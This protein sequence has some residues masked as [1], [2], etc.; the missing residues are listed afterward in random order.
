MQRRPG[1]TL[2]EMLVATGLTIFIMVILSQ[3]FVAGLETFRQL[4]ALGDMESNLR[5][6]TTILR[7]DL[8]ADHFEGKRRLSDSVFWTIGPPREGYFRIWQGS[9]I[10]GP[11]GRNIFEGVDG[12]GLP[13]YRYTDCI[14]AFTVKPRGNRLESFASAIVPAGSPLLAVGL[15]DGRFQN[16]AVNT[17]N[18][19]W[20]EVAYYLRPIAGVTADGTTQLYS[21]FRR[22]RLAVPQNEALNWP[23]G[24]KAGLITATPNNINA[25]AEISCMPVA[26][27]SLYFNSPTDL[28]I[29]QRRFGMDPTQPGGMPVIP[30]ASKQPWTYP[31]YGDPNQ[32]P[33]RRGA[34]VLLT[35]V[36]SF[37]V[38]V[39]LAGQND[40]VD[41]FDPI[42]GNSTNPLFQGA[43][44]PRVFDTW[45]SVKDELYEYVDCKDTAATS[46]PEVMQQRIP[47]QVRIVAVKI[48]LRVWDA[49][50]KQTQQI[51][52]VQDM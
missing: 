1:F 29:P 16:P 13:S 47:R 18:C 2:V 43:N 48:I 49:T 52:V 27:G 6:A 41:L 44:G 4:K 24:G 32:D 5:T 39:L 19:Q 28:T 14:L 42:Y 17:Y 36:V 51:S 12:D 22:Q 11:Q 34:D 10:G 45:S 31:I 23:A 50:T 9:P 21:L 15:P 33:A 25:Y 26:D 46:P 8:S 37:E 38:R 40:F 35:N 7:S 20:Y 30:D 3:A